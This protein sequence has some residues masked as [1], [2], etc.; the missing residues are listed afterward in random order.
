MALENIQLHQFPDAATPTSPDFVYI[1]QN[2]SE[3][4]VSIS[5]LADVFKKVDIIGLPLLSS[6]LNSDLLAIYEAATTT[7]KKVE[8]QKFA[9]YVQEFQHYPTNSVVGEDSLFPRR[10]NPTTNALAQVT[11][12]DLRKQLLRL[13]NLSPSTSSKE[14]DVYC[15]D[16]LALGAARKITTSNLRKVMFDITNVN[17]KSTI[18]GGD[19]FYMADATTKLEVKTSYTT[20]A[21]KITTDLNL[22]QYYGDNR[23]APWSNISGKP[24]QATRWPTWSEVDGKPDNLGLGAGQTWKSYNATQRPRGSNITNTTGRAIFVQIQV[25]RYAP[26]RLYVDGLEV[27]RGF[28]D[29]DYIGYITAIVP[30]G[31][32]YKSQNNTGRWMEL[33]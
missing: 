14:T 27:S 24:A 7:N 9:N 30:A 11:T 5:Q 13:S 26:N 22:G 25:E 15:F 28:C 12:I 6:I 4:R 23:P 2:L 16:D 29:D 10:L 3:K 17:T 19:W 1:S 20:L 8:A 18:V 33:N 21:N 32:S 31:S